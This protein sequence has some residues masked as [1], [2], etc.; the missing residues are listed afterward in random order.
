MKT[1]DPNLRLAI[2]EIQEVLKQRDCMAVINL[3]SKSHGEFLLH[4]DTSWTVVTMDKTQ[5][6]RAALRVRA[7]GIKVGTPAH[8]NLESSLAFVCN[9]A[10]LC[11]RWGQIF[12]GIKAKIAQQSILTHDPL[13]D[14][15]IFNDDREALQ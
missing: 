7:K 11:N 1:Y 4:L 9:S 14:D 6:G 5:D 12:Y 2:A 3:G 13:T 8:E 15:K 10:D